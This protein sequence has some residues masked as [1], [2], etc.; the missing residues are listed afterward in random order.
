MNDPQC[1]V[2]VSNYNVDEE[3]SLEEVKEGTQVGFFNHFDEML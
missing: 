1:P 2:I 3:T